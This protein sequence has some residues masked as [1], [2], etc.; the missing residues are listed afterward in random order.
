[1]RLP[2]L[3]GDKGVNAHAGRASNRQGR[4]QQDQA[5]TALQGKKRNDIAVIGLAKEGGRYGS[6][7]FACAQAPPAFLG[8][9][10]RT[11]LAAGCHFT[12]AWDVCIW[13]ADWKASA[14]HQGAMR[15]HPGGQRTAGP[16]TGRAAIIFC[17]RSLCLPLVMRFPPSL[18]CPAWG[19]AVLHLR[20]SRCRGTWD[21][22]AE[23]CPSRGG[24]A[25]AACRH[26]WW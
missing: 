3:Q 5:E 12:A 10:K 23:N 4:Q 26:R 6:M 14:S 22:T 2:Q 18:A 24:K 16:P 7:I 19:K 8:R 13:L 1:M 20:L 9:C 21:E 15:S 25:G 17:R 11:A